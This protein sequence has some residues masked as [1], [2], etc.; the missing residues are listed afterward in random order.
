MINVYYG[1]VR[2]D[3]YCHKC[4]YFNCK[5]TDSECPCHECLKHDYTIETVETKDDDT[6]KYVEIKNKPICFVESEV[7]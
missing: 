1:E 3:L 6:S 2:F 4:K 7:E 5:Q